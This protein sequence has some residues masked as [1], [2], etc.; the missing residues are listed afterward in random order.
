MSANRDHLLLLL[1]FLGVVGCSSAERLY[2]R[3]GFIS[4]AGTQ[5]GYGVHSFAGSTLTSSSVTPPLASSSEAPLARETEPR[6]TS[7][8]EIPA[9]VLKHFERRSE[10]SENREKTTPPPAPS[11]PAQTPAGVL[12]DNRL[13]ELLEKDLDKAVEQPKERRRL[14]FSKEVIENPKVRHFIKHYSTTAKSQFQT[15]LARSGKYMPMI[16]KVLIEEGLPEELGFL[17]L[18]ESEL[19]VHATSPVGAVGLW[20]FVPAT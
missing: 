16:S 13:L 1:A 12:A 2:Y 11:A 4:P 20:Q 7:R 6:P 8:D 17:A 10:V 18:V 19:I 15:L 14:Q 5:L 3:P 9:H